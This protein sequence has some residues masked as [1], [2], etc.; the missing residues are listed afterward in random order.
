MGPPKLKKINN[1]RFYVFFNFLLFWINKTVVGQLKLIKLSDPYIRVV[2]IR[3]E[4]SYRTRSRSDTV[5][6][7]PREI[8][9]FIYFFM[10]IGGMVEGT[11]VDLAKIRSPMPSGGLEIKLELEQYSRHTEIPISCASG[12]HS[13]HGRGSRLSRVRWGLDMKISMPTLLGNIM[14]GI[15]WRLFRNSVIFFPVKLNR[16]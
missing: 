4:G 8:S 3:Y 1:S 6:H 15:N 14:T 10:E 16:K 11:V 2:Q 7:I 9:R 12:R 5:G 13:L